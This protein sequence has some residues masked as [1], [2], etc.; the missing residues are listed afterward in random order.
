MEGSAKRRPAPAMTAI[1]V[2]LQYRPIR[3][4]WCVRGGDWDDLR[5]AL[6]LTHTLW[7]GHYNPLIPVE[8][9]PLAR[10]LVELFRVDVLYPAAEHES[11]SRFIEDFPYLRWPFIHDHPFTEGIDDLKKPLLLD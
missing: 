11:L 1:S 8:N 5:T 9:R 2:R 6:R 4:G 7:G 3:I 10:Q